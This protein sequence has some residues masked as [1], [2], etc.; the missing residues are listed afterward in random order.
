MRIFFV[1]K[2]DQNELN[3]W[4]ELRRIQTI[5]Y[6]FDRLRLTDIEYAYLKLITVFNPSNQ[7]GKS[8]NM[9]SVSSKDV[10]RPL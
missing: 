5:L 8:I 10:S 3:K 9:T 2:L 4:I 6:E 1:E 7:T